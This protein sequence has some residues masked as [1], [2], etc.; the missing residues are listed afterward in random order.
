MTIRTS[1]L[2]RWITRANSVSAL[3]LLAALPL[4]AWAADPEWT[5]PPLLE[6]TVV[7]SGA[8]VHY[9]EVVLNEVPTGRIAPFV[10]TGGRLSTTA[11]TLRGLGLQ[12]PGSQSATDLDMIVL[13]HLPGLRSEYVVKQQQVKLL[14]PLEMLSGPRRRFGYVPPPPAV[15]DPA[16]R[17]MGLALTYDIFALD[18]AYGRSFSGWSEARVFGKGGVLSNSMVTRYTTSDWAAS[19]W[20]NVRLDTTWQFDFPDR[21]LTLSAGDNVT[22]ALNWT[23]PTRFGG[24]RLSRNFALQPYRI[25]TPLM[26]F[27]GESVLPATVDLFIDGVQRSSSQV[28][29]G[30]FQI[31]SVPWMSGAGQAQVA[32]TDI[33]GRVQLLNFSLYGTPELLQE[34]TSD[35]SVELGMIRKDYGLKSFSYRSEP[36]ISATGRYGLSNRTT[37][38]T[39]VEAT[40]GL[41][42]AGMGGS[43]L[44]GSTAGVL[45]LAAAGSQHESRQGVLARAAYQWSAP[46]FNTG[47][48]FMERSRDFRDVASLDGWSFARR[49][50]QAYAGFGGAFGYFSINFIQQTQN[51]D[52]SRFRRGHNRSRLVNLNWSKHL[53]N[54]AMLSVN[55]YRDLERDNGHSLYVY[56][57]IPF[58]RQTRGAVSAR[59]TRDSES[60][61]VDA[62]RAVHTDLGGWGWRV[63]AAGG[64]VTSGQAEV[65]HLG[66]AGQWTAGVSHYEGGGRAQ[67]YGSASGAV[68]L[69]G[70]HPRAMRR[71]DDAFAMVSTDGVEGVPVRLE[72]RLI[73]HTDADGILLLNRLNAWQR[74]LVSIDTLEL[75]VDMHVPRTRTEA[76]P[77]TRS[78]ALVKFPMRRILSVRLVLRDTQGG[79]LPAGSEV[80]VSGDG[81]LP[82]ATTETVVGF[83]G[84]VYLQDPVGG[85]RLQVRTAD[86]QCQARLPD[87]AEK[88]GLLELGEMV[89]R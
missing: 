19:Q 29:P 87:L 58:D 51:H 63:Q 69:M 52:A 68:V 23:R 85:A 84:M 18:T 6:G 78:G 66:R 12:W 17:A 8:Q 86:A 20:R 70:G 75:P 10:T 88:T 54:N 60:V 82:G 35:W 26:S 47:L 11:Q 25:N 45:S 73:G 64:D 79:L 2:C 28:L 71:V 5:A 48:S 4:E 39:H 38:E 57:S 3:G 46:G 30:Q 27:T 21:M 72:N 33:N 83:D 49:T 24:I 55:A 74:N 80:R 67:A 34:G 1:R 32:I 37:L 40:R 77:A 65:T 16:T 13:D 7:A 62:R 15:I 50:A 56:L 81:M 31:D 36:M 44:L 59:R 42:M 76:V 61:A 9:L 43:W 89:C 53:A 14:A 22:G 41:A